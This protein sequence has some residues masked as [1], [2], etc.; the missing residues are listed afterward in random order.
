M[1]PN[2]PGVHAFFGARAANLDVYLRRHI[3]VLTF[4]RTQRW[5]DMAVTG[6]QKEFGDNAYLRIILRNVCK[7]PDAQLLRPALKTNF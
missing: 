1:G 2:S 5:A 6:L 3:H 7:Y 4:V